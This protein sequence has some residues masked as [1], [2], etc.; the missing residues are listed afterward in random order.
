MVCQYLKDKWKRNYKLGTLKVAKKYD[1]LKNNSAKRDQSKLRKKKATQVYEARKQERKRQG[2]SGSN[3]ENA[4][5]TNCRRLCRLTRRVI[6]DDNEQPEFV[7]GSSH[8]GATGSSHGGEDNDD[9]EGMDVD[10]VSPG[11]GSRLHDKE[12]EEWTANWR[13]GK[14]NKVSVS[15]TYQHVLIAACSTR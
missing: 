6:D 12:E 1:H 10:Q 3:E 5:A 4:G 2:Q 8:D 11:N 14:P 15:I 9:V 13:R 7:Q